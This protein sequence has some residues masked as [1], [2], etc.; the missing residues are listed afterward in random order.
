[1]VQVGQRMGIQGKL[2]FE[3]AKEQTRELI[4]WKKSH[5][6]SNKYMGAIG[7]QYDYIFSPT[8]TGTG[9]ICEVYCNS[10]GDSINLTDTDN[11]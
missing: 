1:M 10:C 5:K 2:M 8:G 6:C 11:W 3:L 7:G 4:E 9:C